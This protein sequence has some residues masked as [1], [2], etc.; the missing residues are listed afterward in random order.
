MDL[1]YFSPTAFYSK[2]ER[3]RNGRVVVDHIY[4][5]MVCCRDNID[6]FHIF[7]D[8]PV[9][10]RAR[11]LVERNNMTGNISAVA[12]GRMAQWASTEEA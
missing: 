9:S 2:N 12:A 10:V 8:A 5:A 11:R 7:L 4:A 1:E 3:L 6:A